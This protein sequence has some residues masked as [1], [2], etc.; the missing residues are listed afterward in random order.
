MFGL[1]AEG[2]TQLRQ[3]PRQAAAMANDKLAQGKLSQKARVLMI[4][5]AVEL[6]F[7]L[8]LAVEEAGQPW[9]D[10]VQEL[11]RSDVVLA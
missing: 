4:S 1:G 5:G 11:Q 2:R 9:V 6:A 8:E 10:K 7:A 3:Q